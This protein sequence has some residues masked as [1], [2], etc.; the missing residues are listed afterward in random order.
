MRPASVPLSAQHRALCFERARLARAEFA[1]E[2]HVTSLSSGLSIYKAGLT[3][4]GSELLVGTIKWFSKV[5]GP[6]YD[7]IEFYERFPEILLAL[8]PHQQLAP[9]GTYTRI[10]LTRV[11]PISPPL[12][13][14]F[15]P[16]SSSFPFFFFSVFHPPLLLSISCTKLYTSKNRREI[17]A[18][19]CK[20]IFQVLAI[21]LRKGHSC[22]L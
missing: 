2:G 7:L 10:Y 14:L 6:V 20:F 17:M 5:V 22:L 4:V 9:D 13:F 18:P 16:P 11:Q 1:P 3:H 15:P 21:K 8:Y 19:T 12:F